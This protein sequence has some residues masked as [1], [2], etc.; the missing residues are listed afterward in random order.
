M[1]DTKIFLV[2]SMNDMKLSMSVNIAKGIIENGGEVFRAENCVKRIN[3]EHCNVFAIPSLIVAKQGDNIQMS[4]IDGSHINLSRLAELNFMSRLLSGEES[5]SVDDYKYYPA[6]ENAALFLGSALMCVY[7]GGAVRDALFSGAIALVAKAAQ[8]KIHG[9]NSFSA[10]L[11]SSFLTGILAN[12]LIFAGISCL[13][14]KIII[15]A[16]MRLVPG[17]MVV[18]ATRDIMNTDIIA[19]AIELFNAVASALAI[20]LGVSISILLFK[21]I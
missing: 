11:L 13:P 5:S 15:G 12:M 7:F 17:I 16:I 19:G 14:D 20:A 9:L 8:E 18:N 6:A 10:T 4:R 21:T 3:S 2:I 1:I